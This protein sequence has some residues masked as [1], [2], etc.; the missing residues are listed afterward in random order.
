MFIVDLIILQWEVIG[1]YLK[2]QLAG[3]FNH[4]LKYWQEVKTELEKL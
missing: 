3:Y 1:N 2:N 4:N